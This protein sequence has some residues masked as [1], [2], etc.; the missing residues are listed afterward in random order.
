MPIKQQ[1][2]GLFG[3]TCLPITL[4]LPGASHLPIHPQFN[5]LNSLS[6]IALPLI[7]FS[8]LSARTAMAEPPQL[9]PVR[10]AGGFEFLPSVYIHTDTIDQLRAWL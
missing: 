5:S 4:K 9:M 6:L 7:A 3:T 1:V 2:G 10:L 8:G